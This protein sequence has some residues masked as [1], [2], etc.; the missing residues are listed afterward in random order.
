MEA[1]HQARIGAGRLVGDTMAGGDDGVG[2]DEK[3]GTKGRGLLAIKGFGRAQAH[4][5]PVG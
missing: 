1:E 2:A 4:A 3:A 5:F